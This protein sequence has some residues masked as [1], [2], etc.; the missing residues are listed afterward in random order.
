VTG[1]TASRET[2]AGGVF[3]FTLRN[4]HG[5]PPRKFMLREEKKQSAIWCDFRRGPVFGMCCILVSDNCNEDRDSF[6][7]HSRGVY[8]NNTAFEDIFTG[9]EKFTVK[10]IEVFEIAD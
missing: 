6:I 2:T 1:V 9:A 7:R 5:V 8:T 4:P 3:L 10:E